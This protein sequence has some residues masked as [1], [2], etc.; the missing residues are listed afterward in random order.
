MSSVIRSMGRS[1]FPSSVT[2]HNTV[3]HNYRVSLEV[4]RAEN[5]NNPH[6][7]KVVDGKV[8]RYSINKKVLFNNEH[9]Y[10][11]SGLY[12]KVNKGRY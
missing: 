12:K 2:P 8:A 7:L 10:R 5:S 1:L 9:G 6:I 3:S 11:V 4:L